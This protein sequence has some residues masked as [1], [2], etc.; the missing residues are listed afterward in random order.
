M[1]KTSKQKIS[2]RTVPYRRSPCGLF[3][4]EDLQ[5]DFPIQ[6]TSYIQDLQGV[7]SIRGPAGGLLQQKTRGRSFQCGRPPG[8]LS[9]I[10]DLEEVFFYLGDLQKVF[11]IQETYLR[12]LKYRRPVG[13]MISLQ[14]TSRGSSLYSKSP[15]GL[16]FIEDLKK[17]FC[18]Q[19]TFFFTGSSGL[20]RVSYEQ[21]VLC[22]QKT[23]RRSFLNRR[24]TDGLF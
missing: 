17:V 12:S 14:K 18:V 9:Y 23:S 19:R 6:K 20:Q 1:Q 13:G 24:P 11:A 10:E 5:E 3:H 7:F 2:G 15:E 22:A 16:L 8:S 4:I 21:K